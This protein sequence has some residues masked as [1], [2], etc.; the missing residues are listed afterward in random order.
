MEK[1]HERVLAEHPVTPALGP[2]QEAKL[3]VAVAL[4]AVSVPTSLLPTETAQ[5]ELALV[6]TMF[7]VPSV[8]STRVTDPSAPLVEG[9]VIVRVLAA[10][11]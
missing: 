2:D 10:V 3:D 9:I 5:G 7:F 1:L 4:L 6:Q 8:V 11:T